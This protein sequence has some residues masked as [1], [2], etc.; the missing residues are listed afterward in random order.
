M[1]AYSLDLRKAALKLKEQGKCDGTSKPI[2]L[3]NKVESVGTSY[4]CIVP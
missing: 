2:G 4:S 3:E 1:R